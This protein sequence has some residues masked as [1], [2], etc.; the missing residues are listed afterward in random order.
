MTPLIFTQPHVLKYKADNSFAIVI[1][2]REE[3]TVTV[4]IPEWP[5]GPRRDA[6]E[7]AKAWTLLFSVSPQLFKVVD[8]FVTDVAAYEAGVIT[9]ER[10]E[11]LAVKLGN[12]PETKVLSEIAGVMERPI[13]RAFRYEQTARS[14]LKEILDSVMMP[15][16][17]DSDLACVPTVLIDK[18]RNFPHRSTIEEVL[19]NDLAGMSRVAGGFQ[20]QSIRIRDAAVDMMEMMDASGNPLKDTKTAELLRAALKATKSI[21]TPVLDRWIPVAES[22]PDDEAEVLFRYL[23]D[24]DEPIHQLG[25]KDGEY[26]TPNYGIN[27]SVPAWRVTHWKRVEDVED[28]GPVAPPFPIPVHS[29]ASMRP[30]IE[31]LKAQGYHPC[32]EPDERQR[33]G[34]FRHGDESQEVLHW[35]DLQPYTLARAYGECLAAILPHMSPEDKDTI[36]RE[37]CEW[38][39]IGKGGEGMA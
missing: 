9:Q 21:P 14:I 10:F 28:E 6:I 11:E 8:Q 39:G 31:A 18:A 3:S 27:V 4:S 1:D 15:E 24:E 23:G 30:L 16:V 13:E 34:F 19:R 32:I 35:K 22:L 33:V 25:C 12:V 38:M 5:N 17:G 36:D 37:A 7:F 29:L 20:K 2:G 26:W